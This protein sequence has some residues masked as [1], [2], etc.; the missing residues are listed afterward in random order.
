MSS[1]YA[2]EQ[3]P[4]RA[5]PAVAGPSLV[6]G[7]AGRLQVSSPAGPDE[8]EAER[9]AAIVAAMPA[10]TGLGG[11]TV[12]R[13]AAPDLEVEHMLRDEADTAATTGEPAAEDGAEADDPGPGNDPVPPDAAGMAGRATGP[14]RATAVPSMGPGVPLSASDRAFFEPRFGFDFG[15]VRVH[16]GAEAAA[17]AAAVGALAYTLGDDVVIGAAGR[18]GG[19]AEDRRFLGHE[20]AHVVQQG[21]AGGVRGVIQ[22]Q[23]TTRRGDVG[24]PVPELQEALNVT[25]SGLTV[26][27]RFGKNTQAAVKTFQTARVPPL[28]GTGVSEAAT[29][30]ALH[31]AAPGD[32]GLPTGETT[33]SNGWAGGGVHRWHQRLEP[34]TTSFRT[35]S[36]T[37]ADPG[38]GTDT[39]HFP[40]SAFAPLTGVTGGTWAV[41]GSNR[42]GDDFVGWFAP[43]VTFYR[44]NGRAPCRAS[45]NQTMRVVRPG[46]DVRYRTNALQME[47]GAST[48]TSIRDGKSETRPFP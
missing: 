28:L 13:R 41:D 47:I 30:A 1:H 29:W 5:Q 22:R 19:T 34:F 7:F 36:V 25:G 32:H 9:M 39:C 18:P 21:A 44:L 27:G 43:A 8:L 4:R 3:T 45:F 31:A 24:C 10:G 42:W 40:G 12:Q 14:A 46:G 37:E 11:G 2:A 26:D 35:C 20:L 16:S 6:A 38:G 33:T 17:S 15:R 48:V 23:P